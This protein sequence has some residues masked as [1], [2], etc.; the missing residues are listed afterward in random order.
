M[1]CALTDGFHLPLFRSI[2]KALAVVFQAMTASAYP[3]EQFD[4]DVVTVLAHVSNNRQMLLDFSA[5]LRSS[6]SDLDKF[7]AALHEFLVAIKCA[8][9]SDQSLFKRSIDFDLMT[10]ELLSL[11]SAEEKD[12]IGAEEADL[13]PAL[14]VLT[15]SWK[16]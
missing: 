3:L 4:Q 10:R 14:S 9:A 15:K 7:M 1:F 6:Y 13:L 5:F 8:S 2:S 16:V 12:A 11:V